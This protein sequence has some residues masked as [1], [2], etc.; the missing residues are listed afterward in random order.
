MERENDIVQ[1]LGAY[2]PRRLAQQIS[3]EGL[4]V[5]GEVRRFSA[6]ALFCDISGFTRMA[7]ELASDGPRGAE[8]LNRVL[9]MTFTAMISLI[10]E[11]G[12]SVGHFYGDAMT[13]FFPER[14]V[15]IGNDSVV[16]TDAA[17][18]A[19]HCSLEMQ[20]VMAASFSRVIANR[21]GGRN[22][23]FHLTMRIGLGYGEC[24]EMVVGDPAESLEYVIGG[25]AIDE[26]VAAEHAAEQGQVFAGASFLRRI[27]IEPETAFQNMG[28]MNFVR[29]ED[30]SVDPPELGTA[31][32]DQLDSEALSRFMH[33]ALAERLVVAGADFLAEHR[34]VTS[35][36]V[37]FEGIDFMAEDAGNRLQL[38]YEWARETVGR[39]GGVNS[40]LNR[41]LTGDK[42]NQLHIIFGAPVAPDS[43][44]QAVRCA[45]AL[46]REKPA[47]ITGQ[48]IGLAVGKVFACPVGSEARRE[49]TVV[50]DV[51][52]LSAR[53]TQVCP[54]NSLLVDGA[55]LAR[56]RTWLDYE[57]LPAVEV[58]GKQEPVP[59]YQAIGERLMINRLQTHLGRWERP[60]IGREDELELLLGGMEAAIRGV[61][62][63]VAIS[64]A[65]G[66]GKSRLLAEGG[67]FWLEN[68]GQ[69]LIGASQPHTNE[70]PFGP[71]LEIWRDFFELRPEMPEEVQAQSIISRIKSLSPE[72]GEEV[73][74]WGEVMG[75]QI[76]AGGSF[77]QLPADVRQAL[78]FKMVRHC[79]QSSARNRPLLIA[80]EDIHWA[81]QASLDLMD[82]LGEYLQE[83]PIFL[84]VT[85]RPVENLA[86]ALL[87]RPVCTPLVLGDLPPGRARELAQTLLGV[88]EIPPGVERHL[89]LRDREGLSS[90]ANPL[91]LEEALR[92]MLENEVIAVN[93]R[94]QV[95]ENRLRQMHVP[96]SIHGLLL[97][98]LDG[99]PAASRDVLQIASVIGRQFALNVLTRIAPR[100]PHGD[101]VELLNGLSVAEMVQLIHADPELTYLFQHAMTQEV[102]YESLPYARRQALHAAIADWLV[103]RYGDNLRPFYPMLAY[104]YSQTDI[105]EKGLEYAL[106]AAN[107]ARDIYAN[108][109]AV[110]LYKLAESHLKAMGPDE[111]WE[112][113]VQIYLSRGEV[114]KLLG[115]FEAATADVE[116]ALA[117]LEKS[118]YSANRAV[119]C[120]LLA[121]IRY[122]QGD[123]PE[124]IVYSDKVIMAT[125]RENLTS[126]TARAYIWRG[127][128]AAA[129][130]EYEQ[131]LDHL[132]KAEAI[133]LA[134]D[135]A[136]RLSGALEALAFVHY[137]RQ[138][139]DQALDV[140]QR[141][142]VIKR[143]FATPANYGI[144]LNN[145]ALIQSSL[146]L[147]ESALETLDQAAAIAEDTSR[148]VF[149]IVLSNRA[150]I[151]SYLGRYEAAE[152]D[153][154]KAVTLFAQ[155]DDAYS[156][157]MA[158][159]LW[160]Y[161]YCLVQERWQEA[162]Y[163]FDQVCETFDFR[164]ENYPEEQTRL[165]IG[166]GCLAVGK[167]TVEKAK[168]SFQSALEIV[169]E[170]ALNWWRPPANYYLGAAY[171]GTGE[172]RM[173]RACF[174]SA[175]E[176]A[177]QRGCPDYLPLALLGLGMVETNPEKKVGYLRECIETA[178]KRA[179]YV[180][181]VYCLKTANEILN[182][183]ANEND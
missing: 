30:F 154:Q 158:H 12:G 179:R 15:S 97:A 29:Q 11:A 72:A 151:L 60:L 105:H 32:F 180:D 57:E 111:W 71:W 145:V 175:V 125:D 87:K 112:T 99:L 40:R 9:L 124:S 116:M 91:F 169:E 109:E 133:S 81:D 90:P 10:H 148:N 182:N 86:L 89:G 131:A 122:R 96:D 123:Y 13:V 167:G 165:L 39:Y 25:P 162:E 6:A 61:G 33:P 104:H 163:H 58:K 101:L 50:G 160:G 157:A 38:Y 173:A 27:G 139:L 21:R 141:G 75:I 67:R 52:N 152:R 45:L 108:R 117:L 63:A 156:L 103:E 85:F 36:F 59:L 135:D 137:S 44:G 168:S 159:L 140:M 28:E 126:E 1:R 76:E 128:A 142:V 56:C 54:E 46:L 34:P 177:A 170:K 172:R 102:A 153:F 176:S 82:A 155:M 143:D 94:V 78:F 174:E 37:Q 42:G 49:Y 7:E 146:G 114:N 106:A 95:D 100:Q 138:E 70:T 65:L 93:G 147:A 62:G 178:E 120:N 107:D 130:L 77:D 84:V 98:R 43:P 80:L 110:E 113:A 88:V 14:A 118:G 166:L 144:A 4:P 31:A 150:E 115:D 35:M 19:W 22:P 68:G 79:F 66:I 23:V 55:A 17:R 119:A 136:Q 129:L 121:E 24:V 18:H 161:E 132:R 3:R 83:A 47:F 48:R 73:A 51:V 53:L 183:P 16:V 171:L 2:I 74:L 149:A 41:V 26:A 134:V 181:R 127:M 5:P 92:V 69:V 20:K 164:S 8:E 64:G